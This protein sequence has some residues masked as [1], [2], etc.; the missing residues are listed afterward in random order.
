MSIAT[1]KSAGLWSAI[2]RNSLRNYASSLCERTNMLADSQCLRRRSRALLRLRNLAVGH[3]M[4]AFAS[5]RYN[6]IGRAGHWWEQHDGG[7]CNR[8]GDCLPRCPL[9][10]PIPDLLAEAHQRLAAPPRRRLWG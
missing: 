6:L 8:C 4:E 1:L 5:E 3:G 2:E 9:G 10:L 7:A